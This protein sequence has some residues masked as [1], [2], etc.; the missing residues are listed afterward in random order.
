MC[1]PGYL[2]IHTQTHHHSN[3]QD[4][5]TL[6]ISGQAN[7]TNMGAV[8]EQDPDDE[9]GGHGPTNAGSKSKGQRTLLESTK[10]AS[11]KEFYDDYFIPLA[12]KFYEH[13]WVN[14][15]Q[16]SA[17]Q[18]MKKNI[19][20][21][22][23][24]VISDFSMNASPK[25][26]NKDAFFAAP[27]ITVLPYALYRKVRGRLKFEG[28][29]YMSDDRNHSNKFVQYTCEDLI[30]KLE[31]RTGTPRA[32]L[33]IHLWTDG[34]AGQYKNS[35]QFAWLAEMAQQGVDI[36]HHF[37]AS[38]HGK[39]PCDALGAWVKN[40]LSRK[41]LYKKESCCLAS[42]A[43]TYLQEAIGRTE[44]PSSASAEGGQG[45]EGEGESDLGG[46]ISC[47]HLE[48]VLVGRD[49][50]DHTIYNQ[51]RT[52]AGS[53]RLHCFVGRNC[54]E[55][56]VCRVS[57]S[58]TS[59]LEGRYEACSPIIRDVLG[60]YERK[61]A[62]I[63]RTTTAA[64]DHRKFIL[65]RSWDIYSKA[66][67]GDFLVAYVHRSDR[68][69]AGR[70]GSSSSQEAPASAKGRF[71]VARLEG[72]PRKPWK[73]S[74]SRGRC[75]CYVSFGYEDEPEKSFRWPA[76]CPG[77]GGKPRFV[78]ECGSE[79]NCYLTHGDWLDVRALRWRAFTAAECLLATR[80]GTTGPTCAALAGS[81]R[82][83]S[84]SQQAGDFVLSLPEAWVKEV[85]EQILSDERTVP[86]DL[87]M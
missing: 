34:C 85:T 75:E 8:W 12:I 39:G 38:H 51:T 44:E 18:N 84:S 64:N 43:V 83:C 31:R 50:V 19:Q 45:G 6:L 55:V 48:F 81:R 78:G 77:E 62:I 66:K 72:H 76:V 67:V 23:V 20:E 46:G 1:E 21:N 86:D 74:L 73:G 79:E 10:A 16:K 24:V 4:C 71:L 87:L 26:E 2:H 56:L 60:Q 69:E 40:T 42:S 41:E 27:Q 9:P 52:L 68:E 53:S 37:F 25:M 5:A 30:R 14:R 15:R 32:S 35:H 80:P 33:V 11:R 63:H 29:I 70:V 7:V 57:C 58:C 13:Q 22:H 65:K 36:R 82:R 47:S 3:P 49:D 28:Y 61:P 17:Y 54:S 59:C